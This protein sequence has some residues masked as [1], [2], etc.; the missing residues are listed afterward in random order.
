MVV[1][2]VAVVGL[3][4]FVVIDVIVVRVVCV[5]VVVA[6]VVIHVDAVVWLLPESFQRMPLEMGNAKINVFCS[7]HK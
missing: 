6:D 1:V 5:A 4:V 2:A 3:F 7:K